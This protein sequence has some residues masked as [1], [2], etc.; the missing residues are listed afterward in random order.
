MWGITTVV[1]SP[2]KLLEQFQWVY[3]RCLPLLN[4]NCHI[5]LPWQLIPERYQGLGMPNYALVSLASKLSFLQCNWGFDVVHSKTIMIEY[6]SFMVEVGL[7]GNTMS[8]KYKKHSMLLTKN[9]WYKNVWELCHYYN[10]W[11]NFIGDLHLKPVRK[12]DKSLMSE[13]MQFG[14]FTCA[15]FVA[16]YIMRMHKNVIHISDIVLCNRKTI[17]PKM[18]TSFPGQFDMH[19]FPTQRPTSSDLELWKRTL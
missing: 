12:G 14:E 19:K 5:N 17:K 1:M 3:F 2:K 10:I 15:D 18:L 7:Y 16:L 13:F 6:E 9:T 4:V 8:Y 11:L